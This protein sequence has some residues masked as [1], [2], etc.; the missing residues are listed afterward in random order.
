MI[1]TAAGDRGRGCL[2]APH[3]TIAG[4]GL[5]IRFVAG[6]Q[7]Y[8]GST[9]FLEGFLVFGG[10]VL[11]PGTASGQ[12]C[13]KS[14]GRRRACA[15]MVNYVVSGAVIQQSTPNARPT[16]A[17]AEEEEFATVIMTPEME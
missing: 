3:D 7:N 2:R 14:R 16:T 9:V 1:V 15:K 4:L 6:G 8:S 13:A 10:V 11:P 12:A 17:A 5:P